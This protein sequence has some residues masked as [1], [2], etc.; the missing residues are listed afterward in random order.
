MMFLERNLCP[1]HSCKRA[2][3]ATTAKNH[4]KRYY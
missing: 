2:H 4:G 3:T 1:W